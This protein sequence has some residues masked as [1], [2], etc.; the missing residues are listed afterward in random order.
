MK[1]FL[2]E[3]VYFEI[4]V[5]DGTDRALVTTEFR[6]KISPMFRQIVKTI[7]M[8]QEDIDILGRRF[9][10]PCSIRCLTEREAL[11]QLSQPSQLK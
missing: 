11:S 10:Y 5:P 3:T 4:S 8:D 2:K 6:D 7:R 1:L 9:G